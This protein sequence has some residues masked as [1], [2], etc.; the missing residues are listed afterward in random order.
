[1]IKKIKAKLSND[2]HFVELLRGSGIAFMFK[3]FGISLGYIFT[4]LIA[5]LYGAETMGLYALSLT[6]VNIFVTVG[7]FGF[8]NALVKF[9]ADY[10]STG[11]I[12]L[13]KEVYIKILLFTIPLGLIL[14]IILYMNADL[15]ANVIF[16][17]ERLVI[18]LQ[19]IALS[20]LPFI[21]LRINSALFRGL[22]DI[23]LFSLFDSFG[24]TVLN[25]IG[26][27][28]ALKLFD[29]SDDIII[30]YIQVISLV[31]LMFMSFFSIKIYTSIYSVISK[32]MLK[33]NEILRV[34]FPML[35]TS[36]IALIMSWTD[37][38]MIGMFRTEG[39][40]GIYSVVVKI[41]T[42]T[43]V[44]LMVVGAIL[45]PKIAEFWTSKDIENLERIVKQSTKLIFFTSLPILVVIIIF[46]N[47]ILNIFGAEFKAGASALIILSINQLF[48]AY[49]GDAGMFLKMTNNQVYLLKLNLFALFLNIVLNYFLIHKF[50]INGAAIATTIALVVA[51]ILANYYIRE[52]YGFNFYL[53]IQKE[54]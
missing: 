23:K 4:L 21:L 5:R 40:V 1:M 53:N 37:I 52:K 11:R 48:Y 29:R 7:I 24:I 20:I 2:I 28:I 30:I 44:M 8:D 35:L 34:S 45:G 50:G 12:Y 26:I 39:E 27:L 32:N 16:K 9:V 36:S 6:I 19:V 46:P 54:K 14:S 49:S 18:F 51:K 3:I 22:K 25:I 42:M 31:V 38:V 33:F 17:K 15:F 47:F 43:S 13:V 41:A 10:N